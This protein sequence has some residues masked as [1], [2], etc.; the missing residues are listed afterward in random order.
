MEQNNRL[1]LEIAAEELAGNK[2]SNET[3]KKSEKK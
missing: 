3:T 1:L 2:K